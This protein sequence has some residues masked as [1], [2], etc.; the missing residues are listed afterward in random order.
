MF[1]SVYTVV[2][3]KVSITYEYGWP[4]SIGMSLTDIRKQLGMVGDWCEAYLAFVLALAATVKDSLYGEF[5]QLDRLVNEDPTGQVDTVITVVVVSVV[6]LV[7]IL[8]YSQVD[9]SISVS[10]E[11]SSA[12]TN[13]TEGF[14]DAMQ[15]L[16]IVLIV[17]VAALV[18]GVIQRFRA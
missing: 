7:G 16:P 5:G 2:R 4:D 10:G 13:L 15:L 6:G 14:S 12:Q 1:T 3:R 17:L 11:L 8:I 18:I 9:S